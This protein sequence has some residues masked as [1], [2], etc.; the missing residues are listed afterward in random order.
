M[1]RSLGCRGCVVSPDV[2]DPSTDPGWRA[3][4]LLDVRP[5]DRLGELD[6][7]AVF[8]RALSANRA[9]VPAGLAS[10]IDGAT[11]L[12][13]EEHDLAARWGAGSEVLWSRGE[14]LMIVGPPGVGKTT[15]AGQLVGALV[16]VRGEVLGLPVERA[17]RVLYLAMDRPRQV[18][19]A[20]SRAFG[21][22]HRDALRDRL[23]VWRGPL[24][25][26]LGKHPETLLQL[27]QRAGCD[28]V[29][30]DSLKD[31]AVKLTDD[32][33]GGNVN[34]AVQLCNAADV[35]VLMLHHQRK[36]QNGSKPT[37]LE[38][39]Y[40]STWLTAGTGSVVLLWGEAGSEV[41]ELTHI[42]QPADTV[43]PWTIEHDHHAGTSSVTRGFDALAFLRLRPNG[44][45]VA[46][47]AQAEHGAPVTA[48]NAKWKRTERRLK[49]L[50]RDGYAVRTGQAQGS[51]GRFDASRY[52][53]VDAS[54]TVDTHRGH[55]NQVDTRGH[56]VDTPWTP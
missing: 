2:Y 27:A 3:A 16:G 28:V 15:L 36:G 46:E 47:A 6:P 24:P 42:K 32:E 39:V 43:G 21:E 7:V 18:Q 14:S 41:V 23:C 11:W 22:Q 4:L 30:V 8:D 38:D 44:A 56:A 53:A 45:T 40:G 51:G 55:D 10:G 52:V 19:R 33:I 13:D 9:D 48:G 54:F 5:E 20:M 31:A 17:T 25:A 26:D 50:E 37:S 34:R 35:D 49:R 29:V 1:Q 12:L